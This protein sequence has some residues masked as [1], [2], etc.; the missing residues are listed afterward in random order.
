VAMVR[1]NCARTVFAACSARG[2]RFLFTIPL[3]YRG[4]AR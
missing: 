1:A 3:K 4:C 2:P